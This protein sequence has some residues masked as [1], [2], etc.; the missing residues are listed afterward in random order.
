MALLDVVD[1]WRVLDLGCEGREGGYFFFGSSDCV[2][3]VLPVE[4]I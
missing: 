3:C 1:L 4:S 2:R